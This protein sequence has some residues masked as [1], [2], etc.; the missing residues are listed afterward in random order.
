MP[1]KSYFESERER[2]GEMEEEEEEEEGGKISK[3][4]SFFGGKS[5]VYTT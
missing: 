3:R 5:V 2:I 4:A 1:K